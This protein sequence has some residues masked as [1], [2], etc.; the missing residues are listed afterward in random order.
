VTQ[1]LSGERAAQVV[2]DAS[3]ETSG[4]HWSWGN[5][6]RAG[7]AAFAQPLSAKGRD[8]ATA[9]ALWDLSEKFVGLAPVPADK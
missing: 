7:R 2:A 9:S 4:V 6:Q 3:F 8:A 1:E 5:R